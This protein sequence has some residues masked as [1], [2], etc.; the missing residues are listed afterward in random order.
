MERVLQV[1]DCAVLVVSGADG[2][3]GHTETLW[4]LLKRYEIP[5]FLFVNK[6]DQDGT[7]R[8][9]PNGRAEN[10]VRRGMR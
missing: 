5:A 4:R 3:Q 10:T 6:M 1:L 9:S 8:D 7:D 2:V